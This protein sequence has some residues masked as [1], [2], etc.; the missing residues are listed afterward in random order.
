MMHP[1]YERLR[2]IGLVADE[3]EEP[4]DEVRFERGRVRA[5]AGRKQATFTYRYQDA[6]DPTGAPMPGS[7]SWHVRRESSVA[8]SLLARLFPLRR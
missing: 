8:R 6:F 3:F 2:V 7:G 5:R 4:L 1:K